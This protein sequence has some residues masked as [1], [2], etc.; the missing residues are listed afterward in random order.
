MEDIACARN[1]FDTCRAFRSYKSSEDFQSQPG[2]Q[3]NWKDFK[4][5]SSSMVYCKQYSG[6]LLAFVSGRTLGDLWRVAGSSRRSIS[7]RSTGWIRD[8]KLWLNRVRLRLIRERAMQ[9]GS[10]IDARRSFCSSDA[11]CRSSTVCHCSPNSTLLPNV[12]TSGGQWKTRYRLASDRSTFP[13]PLFIAHPLI[14]HFIASAIWFLLR[15]T[16]FYGLISTN[17]LTF[18][19]VYVS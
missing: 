3:R 18:V 1:I 6:C 8:F 11:S 5:P 12:I 15:T 14:V 9:F 7:W 13:S 10:V 17:F 19:Q 2:L 4:I 16:R